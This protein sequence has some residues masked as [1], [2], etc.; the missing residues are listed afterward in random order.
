MWKLRNRL[1]AIAGL[2]VL[3]GLFLAPSAGWAEDPHV[4]RRGRSSGA[5]TQSGGNLVKSSDSLIWAVSVNST[6]AGDQVAIYDA[7]SETGNPIWEVTV[8]SATDNKHITF[9]AP[10]KCDTGIYVATTGTSKAWLEYDQ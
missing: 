3:G 5:I 2:A 8:A 10:L 4:Q 6:A 9:T 7:V 1:T